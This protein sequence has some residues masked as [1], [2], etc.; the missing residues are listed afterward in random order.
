MSGRAIWTARFTLDCANR[1][2]LSPIPS[3]LQ[4]ARHSALALAGPPETARGALEMRRFFV[5][6]RPGVNHALG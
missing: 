1:F 2:D 6:D 5:S 3:S 4:P